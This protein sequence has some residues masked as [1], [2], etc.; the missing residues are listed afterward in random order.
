MIDDLTA[1]I[2]ITPDLDSNFNL[3]KL[4]LSFKRLYYENRWGVSVR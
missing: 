4:H 2:K 1:L 3:R